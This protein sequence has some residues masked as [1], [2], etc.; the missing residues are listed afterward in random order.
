MLAP[1]AAYQKSRWAQPSH[2]LESRREGAGL[3]AEGLGGESASRLLQAVGRIQFLGVVRLRSLFPC[4]RSAGV[5]HIPSHMASSIFRASNS[6]LRASRFS[7]CLSSSPV[8]ALKG[9]CDCIEPAPISRMTTL[10]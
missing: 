4:W 6:T 2:R 9:S 1:S 5:T 7:V 8:S 10:L 3:L